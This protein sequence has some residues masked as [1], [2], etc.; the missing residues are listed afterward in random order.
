MHFC[1]LEWVGGHTSSTRTP[2]RT[3]QKME[4]SWG[5]FRHLPIQSSC[6]HLLP[7]PQLP[8]HTGLLPWKLV[9]IAPCMPTH[10]VGPLRKVREW[11]VRLA[12]FLEKLPPPGTS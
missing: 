9:P 7:R 10:I 3:G 6:Y 1:C 11:N 12:T 4:V 5:I 8:V 2:A